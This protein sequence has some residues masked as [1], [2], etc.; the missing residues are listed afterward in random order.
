[1]AITYRIGHDGRLSVEEMDGNFHYIEDELG[2][3]NSSVSQLEISVDDITTVIAGIT[4]SEAYQDATVIAG[5]TASV[6]VLEDDVV[7]LTADVA[8]LT[9]SVMVLED[10]VAG[11]TASVMVLEDDVVG[12]TADVAGLTASVMVLEDDVVGLTADVAGLTASVIDLQNAF[13]NIDGSFN[14]LLLVG[15]VTQ[16]GTFSFNNGILATYSLV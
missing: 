4:A 16:S 9:A 5:L 15:G 2:N 3:L 13:S 11:L 12:L 7:A 10:D 6:M 14:F 1:M 8:G